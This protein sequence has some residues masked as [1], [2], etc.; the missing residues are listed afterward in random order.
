MTQF[1]F[2]FK[3]I[4]FVLIYTKLCYYDVISSIEILNI[5]KLYYYD[6]I[7]FLKRLYHYITIQKF[8]HKFYFAL[9]FVILIFF[10]R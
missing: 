4:K 8:I 1:Q 9:L 5:L 2:N 6:T 7:S 3:Y 10:Y